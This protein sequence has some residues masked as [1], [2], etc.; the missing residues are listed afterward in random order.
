MGCLA[1][2]GLALAAPGCGGGSSIAALPGTGGTGFTSV[3]TITGFGS[4]KVNGVFFDDSLASV[5]IDGQ[6][7][8]PA[9]LGLGMQVTVLG[10][11]GTVAATGTAKSIEVWSQAQGLVSALGA[12][13]F[14]VAGMSVST[15]SSTVYLG[16]AS[17]AALQPGMAVRVWGLATDAALTQWLA[18]R[19]EALAPASVVTSGVVAA[20]GQL[21]GLTLKGALAPL[22]TGQAVRVSGSLVGTQL[23]VASVQ[24]LTAGASTGNASGDDEQREGVITQLNSSTSFLLGD[25]PMDLSSA[26]LTGGTSL[27]AGAK[28]EITG[29]W[30]NGVFQ[31][32]QVRLQSA[33]DLNEVEI[34]G[35]IMAFV[36]L[37]D[38]TVR[39]QR[40]DA[41]ALS[42]VGGGQLSDLKTGARVHLHGEKRGDVIVVTEIALGN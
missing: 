34:K 32:S 35:D 1:L 4:V 28:A 19:V 36:S 39:G 21:N 20:S 2:L 42:Q 29:H 14:Q 15:D 16:V 13:H 6:S 25:L 12:N 23:T 37:A 17:T 5:T 3:G 7:Q 10:Q 33:A 31:V 8:T 11:L 30:V 22:S 18:T 38:F 27:S 26:V 40:C 24:S 41:S 9:A